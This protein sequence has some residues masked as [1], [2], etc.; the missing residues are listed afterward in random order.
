MGTLTHTVPTVA[1]LGGV[2]SLDFTQDGQGL[3][4]KLPKNRPDTMAWSLKITGLK[5]KPAAA[6]SGDAK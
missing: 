4:V 3:R 1:L 6:G 2:G 5:L